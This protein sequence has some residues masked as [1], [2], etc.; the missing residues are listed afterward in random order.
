MQ[1]PNQIELPAAL[2][3]EVSGVLLQGVA[4]ILF[5]N[6][7]PEQGASSDEIYTDVEPGARMSVEKLKTFLNAAPKLEVVMSIALA[8]TQ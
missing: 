4:K 6:L 7:I 3:K 5:H 2:S 1:Y 8:I